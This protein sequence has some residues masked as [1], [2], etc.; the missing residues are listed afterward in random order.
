MY[1]QAKTKTQ[2]GNPSSLVTAHLSAYAQLRTMLFPIRGRW[3]FFDWL[4]NT[5]WITHDLSMSVL[6]VPSLMMDWAKCTG[7][8]GV[9]CLIY[10]GVQSR[11]EDG[12]NVEA[13]LHPE[14]C[15]IS[16]PCYICIPVGPGHNI[17][18]S[19]EDSNTGIAW[20]CVPVPLLYIQKVQQQ[21]K[22]CRFHCFL[23]AYV[24]LFVTKLVWWAQELVCFCWSSNPVL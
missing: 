10:E 21:Y 14:W 17:D 19:S 12:I 5:F 24:R 22:K 7:R 13:V 3:T 23:L 16:I 20:R 2:G 6:V 11:N 4:C 8:A 18:N 1:V 9:I 15:Q